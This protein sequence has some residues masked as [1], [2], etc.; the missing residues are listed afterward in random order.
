MKKVL[1]KYKKF[2]DGIK[3]NIQTINAGKSGE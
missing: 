1:E 3:Y 2:W